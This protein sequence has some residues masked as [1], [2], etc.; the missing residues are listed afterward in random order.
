MIFTS[1]L[2]TYNFAALFLVLL[3][4]F[5]LK[6]LPEKEL[7]IKSYIILGILGLLSFS[8]TITNYVIFLIVCFVLWIF[9]KAK[10]WKLLVTGITTV[11]ALFIFNVGQKVIWNNTAVLW[12]LNT[13][14]EVIDFAKTTID[15]NNFKRVMEGDYIHSLISS[16]IYTTIKTL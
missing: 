5:F 2:E 8:M 6:K 3:W 4:Y 15:F 12:H 9:K 1:A 16:D 7:N 13:G 10:F 14:N 11:L